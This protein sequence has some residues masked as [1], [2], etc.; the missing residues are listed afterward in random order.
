MQNLRSLLGRLKTSKIN[1]DASKIRA[2]LIRNGLRNLKEKI[3]EMSEDKKRIER[4]DKI[5]EIVEKIIGFN[6]QNKQG[7]RLEI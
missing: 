5:M 2:N 6:E 1:T 7:E 4:P 3:E